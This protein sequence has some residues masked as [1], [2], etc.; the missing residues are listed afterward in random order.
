MI[1]FTTGAPA[2]LYEGTNYFDDELDDMEERVL[3]ALATF[4]IEELRELVTE[5]EERLCKGK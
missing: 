5:I 3:E 1:L 4:T 2:L